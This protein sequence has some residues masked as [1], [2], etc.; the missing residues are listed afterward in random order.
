MKKESKSNPNLVIILISVLVIVLVLILIFVSIFQKNLQDDQ[1]QMPNKSQS[2]LAEQGI[3]AS[4]SERNPEQP[5]NTQSAPVPI[6]IPGQ[7]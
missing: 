2:S 5:V 6:V 1:N 7:E 4:I 3:D